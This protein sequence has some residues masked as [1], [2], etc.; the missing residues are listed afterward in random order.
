MT[1]ALKYANLATSGS[2]SKPQ[3]LI[4]MRPVRDSESSWLNRSLPR[5]WKCLNLRASVRGQ[6][7]VRDESPVSEDDVSR[8]GVPDEK[9]VG[10]VPVIS[11][12]IRLGAGSLRSRWQGTTQP[13]RLLPPPTTREHE[14]RACSD[15]SPTAASGSG[16]THHSIVAGSIIVVKK[17]T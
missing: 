2:G 11:A 15:A 16:E 6:V 3:E 5:T 13:R 1:P 17:E 8:E 9:A 4:Q 14:R 7:L 10:Q 12:E